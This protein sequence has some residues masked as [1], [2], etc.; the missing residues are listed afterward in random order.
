MLKR[1]DLKCKP[2]RGV[3]KCV[4]KLYFENLKQQGNL[5]DPGVFGSLLSK[6]I[7]KINL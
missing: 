5:G 3:E 2:H 1:M 6:W 7:L 4:A